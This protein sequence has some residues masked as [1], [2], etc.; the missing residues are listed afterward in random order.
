MCGDDLQVPLVRGR[1][2]CKLGVHINEVVE[3]TEWT[4]AEPFTGLVEDYDKHWGLAILRTDGSRIWYNFSR[5][6]LASTTGFRLRLLDPEQYVKTQDFELAPPEFGRGWLHRPGIVQAPRK[7]PIPM[8]EVDAESTGSSGA[9]DGSN[10]Q[11]RWVPQGLSDVC[12][13]AQ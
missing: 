8:P 6:N 3:V 13:I 10:E 9:F 11:S 1:D 2:C 12:L 4:G 5:F 7:K